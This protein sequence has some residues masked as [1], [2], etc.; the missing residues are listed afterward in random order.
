MHWLHKQPQG[1]Q[2]TFESSY[3][4]TD[5][6]RRISADE[7]KLVSM[8]VEVT[9]ALLTTPTGVKSR[10]GHKHSG[11][12]RSQCTQLLLWA[13]ASLHCIEGMEVKCLRLG[14]VEWCMHLYVHMC[15]RTWLISR[16]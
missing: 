13:S 4:A 9:G 5:L 7:A 15:L 14:P 3:C 11:C 6:P 16:P 10:A 2:R 8:W 1:K 12:S